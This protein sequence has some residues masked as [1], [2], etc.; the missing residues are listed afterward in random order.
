MK[1]IILLFPFFIFPA[2]IFGQQI[3]NIDSLKLSYEISTKNEDKYRISSQITDLYKDNDF[4]KALVFALKSYQAANNLNNEDYRLEAIVNLANIYCGL[5]NYKKSM[6]V[7]DQGESIASKTSNYTKLADLSIIKGKINLEL[8]DYISS[9]KSFFKSLKLFEQIN[10]QKGIASALNNIGKQYHL[11]GQYNKSMEYFFKSLNISK[12]DKDKIGIA[13]GLGNI[14]TIYAKRNELENSKKYTRQA[15]QINR[16][17]GKKLWEGI[18]YY[19]LGTIYQV[20]KNY[21]SALYYQKAGE[22]IFL[23][24]NNI[25]MLYKSYLDLSEFYLEINNQEMALEYANKAYNLGKVYKLKQ[26]I[27]AASK[28]LHEIYSLKN[29]FVN[30]YKYLLIENQMKDSLHLE[31]SLKTITNLELKAEIEKTNQKETLLNQRKDLIIITLTSSLLLVISLILF[32]FFRQ[33]N[34][35]KTDTLNRINLENEVEFKNKELTLNVIN[36]IKK[37]EL[38]NDLAEKLNALKSKSPNEAFKSD[39]QKIITELQKNA[40][41]KTGEEFEIRFKQVHTGFYDRLLQKYPN[42]SPNELKLCAFLRLNMTTKDI[43]NIT[44]QR[45]DSIE[46][47]RHRLR[48]KLGI[49]N[50]QTNLIIFLSQF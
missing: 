33:K 44:G 43:S 42:L 25:A 18:N 26:T 19:N 16:Q 14:A 22:S 20:E 47:A 5:T 24:L 23:K 6:F 50:T 40:S 31:E 2:I 39:I 1:I 32:I 12:K 9:S 21:D 29:D 4:Q 10:D 3:A 45:T 15:I 49:T 28:K 37:N 48:T 36:Q 38:I 17:I 11:Q 34:K 27:H 41:D 30:A 7:V 13:R 46:I 35:V 8:G